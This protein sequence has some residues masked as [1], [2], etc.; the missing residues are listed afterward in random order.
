MKNGIVR[1]ES[2]LRS[3]IKR[4]WHPNDWRFV[5]DQFVLWQLSKAFMD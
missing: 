3:E 4:K 5:N 2:A 1:F